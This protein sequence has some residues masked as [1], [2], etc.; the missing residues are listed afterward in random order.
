VR[1]SSTPL[2]LNRRSLE[3]A[4]GGSDLGVVLRAVRMFGDA[5]LGA[6]LRHARVFRHDLTLLLAVLQ[7]RQRGP[8]AIWIIGPRPGREARLAS[9]FTL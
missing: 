9:H 2:G 4:H 1:P 5:E 3:F 8:S 7:V 6:Q